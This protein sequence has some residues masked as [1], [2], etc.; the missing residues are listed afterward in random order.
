MKSNRV[1]VGGYIQRLRE[2][3]GMTITQLAAAFETTE[4][5]LR[6]IEKGRVDTNELYASLDGFYRPIM[7]G[8]WL[9]PDLHPE[10]RQ[11]VIDMQWQLVSGIRD[12]LRSSNERT[13]NRAAST[14][15]IVIQQGIPKDEDTFHD[16]WIAAGMTVSGGGDD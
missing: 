4:G 9:L 5:Q 12:N 1:A 16:V 14:A 6:N 15:H 8:E 13:R 10:M 2:S 7:R 3:R 11:E